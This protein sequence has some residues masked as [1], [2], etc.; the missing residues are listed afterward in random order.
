MSTELAEPPADEMSFVDSFAAF[1]N[2]ASKPEPAPV[3]EPEPPAPEPEPEKPVTTEPLK[4]IDDLADKP[5]LELP[6][7]AVD[8][9]EDAPE[10]GDD[11]DNPYK[12]GT[13]TKLLLILQVMVLLE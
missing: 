12:A 3:A 13:Q 2:P 8:G 7:D 5:D 10:P 11:K 9:D 4:E 6:T 1:M